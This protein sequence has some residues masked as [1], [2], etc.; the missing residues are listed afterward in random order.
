MVLGRS[1]WPRSRAVQQRD[2]SRW[3]GR[4]AREACKA[5]LRANGRRLSAEPAPRSEALGD[6]LGA[7]TG[8]SLD[9]GVELD[10]LANTN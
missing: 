7:V 10:A 5:I 2:G 9:K 1:D 6:G 4:E 8:T 3:D